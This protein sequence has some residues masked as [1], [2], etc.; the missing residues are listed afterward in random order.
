MLGEIGS[1][2]NTPPGCRFHPRC[3]HARSLAEGGADAIPARCRGADPGAAGADRPV[4]CHFPIRDD[5][6]EGSR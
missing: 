6:K 3:A 4:A 5:A 1:V 2:T